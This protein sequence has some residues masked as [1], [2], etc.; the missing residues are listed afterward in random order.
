MI[1][2]QENHRPQKCAPAGGGEFDTVV[3]LK[4]VSPQIAS[5]SLTIS[6]VRIFLIEPPIDGL[7]ALV[8]CVINGR[9]ALK[10]IAI[11]RKLDGSGYRLTYPTK[12][13]GGRDIT[14]FHPLDPELSKAVETAIFVAYKQ[15]L[16][17]PSFQKL[18]EQHDTV[19]V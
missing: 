15:S 17:F 4:E 5:Q 8:S 9:I 7:V 10:S 2:G 11:H 1:V 6:D 13:A 16:S 14:L 19:T 3:P 18:Y 12:K